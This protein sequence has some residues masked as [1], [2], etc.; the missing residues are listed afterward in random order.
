MRIT[1]APPN[2]LRASLQLPLTRMI[3]PPTH[4]PPSAQARNC[5]CLQAPGAPAP[6]C[7]TC[8]CAA[9]AR[10]TVPRDTDLPLPAVPF[11]LNA[12]GSCVR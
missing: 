9:C 11:Y 5:F 2:P 4:A 1:R 6:N 12:A 10:P 7:N 3:R 8:K